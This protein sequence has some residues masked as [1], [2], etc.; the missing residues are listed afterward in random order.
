MI[1]QIAALR[2]YAITNKALTTAI[3]NQF[4]LYQSST[5]YSYPFLISIVGINV[6]YPDSGIGSILSNNTLGVRLL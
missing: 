2:F 5:N 6:R 3:N 4:S 1:Q